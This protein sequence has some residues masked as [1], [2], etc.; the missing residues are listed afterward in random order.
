MIRKLRKYAERTQSSNTAAVIA[1]SEQKKLQI[2]FRHDGR[3]LH[4]VAKIYK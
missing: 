3:L 2:Q 1:R 4:N